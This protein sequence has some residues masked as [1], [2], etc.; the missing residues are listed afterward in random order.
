MAVVFF[1]RLSC[2]R[3]RGGERETLEERQQIW[4]RRTDG[5]NVTKTK[6]DLITEKAMPDKQV[7]GQVLPGTYRLSGQTAS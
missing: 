2:G 7:H 3:R 1:S 4:E 5:K 6:Q